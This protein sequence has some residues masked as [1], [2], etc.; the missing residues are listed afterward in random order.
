MEYREAAK[1]EVKARNLEERR[2]GANVLCARCK[3]GHVYRRR[4]SLEL[5]IYCQQMAKSVPP[6]IEE[7]N[8]FEGSKSLDI[9]EMTEVALII[10]ARVGVSDKSYR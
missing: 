8:K 2:L 7:C 1:L 6:D 9:N 10:D 4:G 3:H 5:V